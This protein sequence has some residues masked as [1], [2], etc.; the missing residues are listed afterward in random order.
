MFDYLLSKTFSLS[1]SRSEGSNYYTCVCVDPNCFRKYMR[2]FI[3]E[4]LKKKQ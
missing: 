1:P 4:I 2:F 3:A